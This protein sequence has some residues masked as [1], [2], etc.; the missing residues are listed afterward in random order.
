MT[1]RALS[2]DIQNALDFLMESELALYANPVS[3][4][5]TRVTWHAVGD[6]GAFLLSHGFT[7]IQ[8]YL[9]WVSAGAYSVALRDGSLLQLT[10]DING[11]GVSGHRLAYIPCPAIIDEELL[12]SGEPIGDV[13]PLFLDEGAL[14]LTMRSPIRFDYD[15]AA[16]REGHPAAHFSINSPDC[17]IACV[18][19]VHPYRFIDFVFRH[20]YPVFRRVHASWFDEAGSRHLGTRVLTDADRGTFH[21]NWPL[22]AIP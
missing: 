15:P 17:R 6:A 1:S 7:T 9:D 8:Q 19:P 14:P 2:T 10:Y 16:A 18:A 12:L 3:M 4:T 22:D 21:M 20:F 11:G 13:V 5:P